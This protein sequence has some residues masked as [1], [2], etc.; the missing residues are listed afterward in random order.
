MGGKL[1]KFG[2]VARLTIEQVRHERGRTALVVLA[3]G[4][5][6]L[7]VTLL[8][9]LGLGVIQTGE[10]RFDRSGQDV[11]VAGESVELTATGGIENPITDAHGL[12]DEMEARDDVEAASPLAFHGIYV[13]TEPDELELVTGVGV[14]SEHRGHSIEAGDGF[15]SGES[16]YADGTYEGPMSREIVV[17]PETAERF[18]VG[19]GDTVYVGT[20]PTTAPDREFEVVGI[21]STY[22]QFLGTATVTLPLGEL[23]AVTGTTGPD[24][25]TYVTVTTAAD[26]D[27]AAVSEALQRS[28]PEYDVRTNEEQLESM[29]REYLLVLASGVTLVALAVLAGVALT[30]NTL[31]LVAAHQRERLAALRAIGLSRG[32]LAG[33]VGGQGFVLG[34]LGGALGLAATPAFA[35]ALDRLAA[36]VVGF[37]NL[38]RTPPLLYGVGFL[39]AVGIGTLG[40][41]VAGWRA[42]GYARVDNLRE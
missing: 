11:W 2:A 26:A 41:V 22:S 29:L 3:I 27:P 12:A 6:V 20:S 24:R 10:D 13:G 17:D 18:D 36:S 35:A 33:L 42:A 9:S 31:A 25:A 8:G 28:Y 4:L 14:P 21:S 1:A 19:V 23:Q 37:E 7:A 38:L 40:A 15:S 32:L 16:H 39:I 5:A 34:M 30:V